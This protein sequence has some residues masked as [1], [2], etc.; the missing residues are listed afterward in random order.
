MLGI[1]ADL[2]LHVS[3]DLQPHA[4]CCK[5]TLGETYTLPCIGTMI[6][7]SFIHQNLKSSSMWMLYSSV[8]LQ[9][10]TWSRARLICCRWWEISYFVDSFVLPNIRCRRSFSDSIAFPS[11]NSERKQIPG[12]IHLLSSEF[13]F[14]NTLESR[15]N[16]IIT[17]N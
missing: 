12:A 4:T 13:E 3:L 5:G 7:S 2:Q 17:S 6:S 10:S 16:F 14:A 15:S 1:L 11:Y 8:S 9:M